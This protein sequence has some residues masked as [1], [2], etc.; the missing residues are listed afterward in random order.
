MLAGWLL[1]LGIWTAVSGLGSGTHTSTRLR[2]QA[3]W[4]WSRT[5]GICAIAS[6]SSGGLSR[7]SSAYRARTLWLP[8]G[9]SPA[10]RLRPPGYGWCL[11]GQRQLR[12]PG[13]PEP[14]V[15]TEVPL[16]PTTID[17]TDP[18]FLSY[19]QT[20]GTRTTADLAQLLRAAGI[21]VW[22]DKDDLPPGDTIARLQ[23]AIDDGISVGVLV[24][25]PDI[26]YSDIVRGTEAP[27]LLAL[28]DK[29][30]EFTLGIV[31]GA[32]PGAKPDYAAPD[33][34]LGLPVGRL[35]VVDQQP[36]SR[37][38]LRRLTEG[39]L[40]TRVALLRGRVAGDD[41]TLTLSIQ[42][43][44]G[45]Q[46]YD[47]RE[48]QLDIRLK[49]TPDGRL[50]SRAGLMDF[51]DTISFLPDAV[52]RSG[53]RRV[54]VLGGAH[55]SVALALGAALPSTRVGR[56]EVVHQDGALWQ[57][58]P[59]PSHPNPLAVRV[60]AE[61]H[62]P[63][64][65]G[66]P[67]VAAYVDLLSTPSDS[68]FD[69]FLEEQGS[70]LT[71]WR[72]LKAVGSGLLDPHDAGL[73]AAD[74]AA[75]IRSLSQEDGNAEVHLLLRCPFPVAVLLGRLTNTLRVIT[76]EWDNSDRSAGSDYRPRYVPCLRVEASSGRGAITEVLLTTA[77]A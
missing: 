57:S 25:T 47:H 20:D 71:A 26:Q 35:K 6:F 9:L 76:Y 74:L 2:S 61:G 24:I 48:G 52:T 60:H 43:R 30:P 17:P 56:M 31:N 58:G 28:H 49:P 1:T 37:T 67:Q 11:T 66:R 68:A 40:R 53:A 5:T 29:F 32:S 33:R 14:K 22:R 63:A 45:A 8:H 65:A 69:R 70:R 50:P 18:V 54:R 12:F 75:H 10:S 16:D 21:P 44:N 55:L 15:R 42:T 38:G 4:I 39:L 51:K 13:S 62:N 77:R 59:E 41:E 23:E 19:R 36:T 64:S 46:V 27:R 73:I 3:M 7:L 72:H 34:L